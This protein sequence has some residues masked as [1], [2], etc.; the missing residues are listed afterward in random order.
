[1]DYNNY[2]KQD[3]RESNSAWFARTSLKVGVLA[4]AFFAASKIKGPAKELYQKYIKKIGE[5][6]EYREAVKQTDSQ[7]RMLGGRDYKSF[8]K[9]NDI[10]FN[11]GIRNE[12]FD[13]TK[14]MILDEIYQAENKL[15]NKIED[16]INLSKINSKTKP[17][18][19]DLTNIVDP[20]SKDKMLFEIRVNTLWDYLNHHMHL[21]KKDYDIIASLKDPE[22]DSEKAAKLFDR[23][24]TADP[25]FANMY[26]KNIS[27]SKKAYIASTKKLLTDKD[28]ILDKEIAKSKMLGQDIFKTD[29]NTAIKMR[30]GTK[31]YTSIVIN[32]FDLFES[33]KR[34]TSGSLDESSYIPNSK[35]FRVLSG[36][37]YTSDIKKLIETTEK[38]GEKQGI[39]SS[40]TRI[41]G[42]GSS[43]S[44]RWYLEINFEHNTQGP[45]SVKVPIAQH[46]RLPAPNSFGTQKYDYIMPTIING[47][48]EYTNTTGLALKSAIKTLHSNVMDDFAISP[49][50]AIR[51]LQD[52]IH[53]ANFEAARMEGTGRDLINAAKIYY[54]DKRFQNKQLAESFKAINM[55]RDMSRRQAGGAIN[56]TLDLE[57]ITPGGKEFKGPNVQ[58]V[59]PLT[60]IT[61]AGYSVSEIDT[62][63]HINITDVDSFFSDHAVEVMNTKGYTDDH[64]QWLKEYLPIDKRKELAGK[65][66]NEIG[67]AW[68]NQLKQLTSKQIGLKF[69]DNR[70][71]ARHLINKLLTIAKNNPGKPIYI[72]T[73]FGTAFDLKI[74]ELY[75]PV[76]YNKL[77][78]A[79]KHLDIHGVAH[80]QQFKFG[81]EESLNQSKLLQKLMGRFGLKDLDFSKS[82]D[83]IKAIGHIK[84]FGD[85]GHGNI[86][87]SNALIKKLK[88]YGSLAAHD[89]GTDAVLL[90]LLTGSHINKYLSNIEK[91]DTDFAELQH[92]F[93]SMKRIK[94]LD[95]Q[96]EE[97]TSVEK[98]E[99][100][101]QGSTYNPSSFALSQGQIAKYA[102]SL[103]ST[104]H[105]LTFPDNNP[106]KQWNQMMVG[107]PIVL[108]HP[109]GKS[110]ADITDLKLR[111]SF[112]KQL[113]PTM[114]ARG[115]LDAIGFSR[116]ADAMTNLFSHTL[117]SK[118]VALL[119]GFGN[120]EGGLHMSRNLFDKKN[121]TVMKRGINLSDIA[122]D[123]S[124]VHISTQIDNLYKE[125]EKKAN[126]IAELSKGAGALPEQE[127]YDEAAKS[128]I[129]ENNPLARLPKGHTVVLT[130]GDMG[131]HSFKADVDG[132]LTNL[133]VISSKGNNIKVMADI[134]Y[135]IDKDSNMALVGRNFGVKSV[136][137]RDELLTQG[138]LYEGAESFGSAQFLEKNYVGSMKS[139]VFETG[140]DNLFD[141]YNNSTIQ[142]EKDKALKLIKKWSLKVNAD[143][144]F[145]HDKIINRSYE[146]GKFARINDA[147]DIASADKFLGNVNININDMK[148]FMVDTKQVWTKE[149][150]K[151]YYGIFS[152]T[153]PGNPMDGF[154]NAQK[155]YQINLEKATKDINSSTSEVGKVLEGLSDPERFKIKQNFTDL[156]KDFSL[157]DINRINNGELVPMFWRPIQKMIG[158]G[159]DLGIVMKGTTNIYGGGLS[160]LDA[161]PTRLKIRRSTM[162]ILDKFSN[163][164]PTS[165]EVY[166]KARASNFSGKAK[167]AAKSRD[168]FIDTILSK[169]VTKG[170]SLD[171]TEIRSILDIKQGLN[172]D[173]LKKYSLTSLEKEEALESAYEILG[174]KKPYSKEITAAAQQY[175]NDLEATDFAERVMD[176]DNT[177]YISNKSAMN[178][179]DIGKKHSV[180]RLS[181]L[182]GLTDGLFSLD[183][184]DLMSRMVNK[185]ELPSTDQMV[186]IFRHIKEQGGGF[187]HSIDEE[188]KIVKLKQ[189]I[190]ETP[191]HQD[192]VINLLNP[193][194]QESKFGIATDQT[195]TMYRVMD[196][197]EFLKKNQG[198]LD[199]ITREGHIT[200]LNLQYLHYF[201]RGVHSVEEDLHTPMG[202]TAQAS[203]ANQVYLKFRDMKGKWGTVLKNKEQAVQAE[204]LGERIMGDFTMG[205]IFVHED[206]YKNNFQ[207]DYI[208][209]NSN[210]VKNHYDD[211]ISKFGKI[212]ADKIISEIALPGTFTGFPQGPLGIDSVQ[213]SRYN[214]IPKFMAEYVGINRNMLAATSEYSRGLGRDIDGDNVYGTIH[215]YDTVEAIK[216]ASRVEYKEYLDK[217]LNTLVKGDKGLITLREKTNKTKHYIEF[218]TKGGMTVGGYN[219]GVITTEHVA[220]GSK[221][222]TAAL[223]GLGDTSNTLVE[224]IMHDPNIITAQ[225]I[226][227][228]IELGAMVAV[229]KNS[230]GLFSN[231]LA[232]RSRTLI[233]A[234]IIQENSPFAQTLIGNISSGISGAE[235]LPISL[236]KHGITEQVKRLALA[237]K[238]LMNPF[239]KD[240][241]SHDA[242][243][244]VIFQEG[245]KLS[246][247]R[248]QEEGN[249]LYKTLTTDIVDISNKMGP[250]EKLTR[251]IF[252]SQ[253]TMETNKEFSR[254]NLIM[255]QLQENLAENV[256]S[257]GEH[258]LGETLVKNY[259]L[260]PKV[261]A[262][263]KSG[264]TAGAVGAAIYLAG[265][266]F[267]PHQ[268]SNSSNP[269][270]GF[271]DLG[272]DIDGN[273]KSI[274]S[275]LELERSVPL[276]M[277]DASFSKQ[278]YIRMNKLSNGRINKAKSD[279]IND[280]L[281]TGYKTSNPLMA[282]WKTS[283]NL[284]YTNNGSNIGYFGSSQLNRRSNY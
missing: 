146:P 209:E 223:H 262:I 182:E 93:W 68:G 252:D 235:Q 63:G 66:A 7:V 50:R 278:A 40:S 200:S 84:K 131:I 224:M 75:D 44:K 104:R 275:N 119:P 220:I 276:D 37:D 19:F 203:D 87:I 144:D 159:F 43:E 61:Q 38:L 157:P 226:N 24:L 120:Q 8:T 194:A 79:T 258:V 35:Q 113:L 207:F 85:T 145:T 246:L 116:N 251:M 204:K 36:F 217:Q 222:A 255:S 284:T 97:A 213:N 198:Q 270:D 185:E 186:K 237:S 241:M 111:K 74:L 102:S 92:K 143:I 83:V 138:L 149:N 256:P 215:S 161:R 11:T 107:T 17:L 41:I 249:L 76:G 272:V 170:I 212:E 27:R 171:D 20:I 31:R 94:G 261:R 265:N 178:I 117:I 125:I 48:K 166:R 132:R 46:G 169:S 253:E 243:K 248:N 245:S 71:I 126:A 257:T 168:L 271:V 123:A 236:G 231:I 133:N 225:H 52:S 112:A 239:N 39:K 82:E 135:Q 277:V 42:E 5:K 34:I 150:V 136:I 176:K 238:A 129:R 9:N 283:S 202:F 65:S 254:L 216:K 240:K 214:V 218:N 3:K 88:Q 60:Q 232:K 205:D 259:K 130:E 54:H 153:G 67:T 177:S 140:F 229:S 33:D 109:L 191:Q 263:F 180:F 282:D 142:A 250:K 89:A 53:N 59:D 190:L 274:M 58:A 162:E 49:K 32:P 91:Y 264:K 174:G 127:H 45:F 164:T 228:K 175:V 266:F 47:R 95:E 234:G 199:S 201:M 179:A 23:Y 78:S 21:E 26:Q 105:F 147:I 160:G 115:E 73:K 211:L 86:V 64:A 154:N 221:E 25:D 14:S 121:P 96:L 81:G 233:E 137:V 57:T 118:H 158:K 4:G 124:D 244:S 188:N 51:K 80:Y 267:R 114:I 69:K 210:V 2:N 141:I 242:L 192:S 72:T 99:V 187:I 193:R 98:M 260:N 90:H 269:L 110:I 108:N 106:A 1:M 227:S 29:I 18:G 208:K 56:I 268:M 195:K 197:Y 165:K 184:N 16:D 230:I 12:Y 156:I 122:S 152:N 155:L 279:I 148:E 100:Y 247:A 22:K 280:I 183:L 128:I 28:F 173:K 70:D 77:R 172:I 281:N 181:A 101:I 196:A 273:H 62:R 163:L 30:V 219:N 139:I 134:E 6:I 151:N 189:L 167:A 103:V 55:L 15:V 13:D 10:E 206:N